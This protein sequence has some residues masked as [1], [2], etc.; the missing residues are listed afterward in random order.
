MGVGHVS[1]THQ[2]QV[3]KRQIHARIYGFGSELY[4]YFGSYC[5]GFLTSFNVAARCLVEIFG[6]WGE[7]GIGTSNAE[8][9]SNCS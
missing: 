4:F 5:F 8:L 1:V 3:Q 2:S 9:D 6:A 7:S